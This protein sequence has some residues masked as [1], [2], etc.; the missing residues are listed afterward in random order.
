MSPLSF[1]S[2]KKRC[3]GHFSDV[4]YTKGV[5]WVENDCVRTKLT[6]CDTNVMPISSR[7]LSP[8]LFLVSVSIF[9][10]IVVERPAGLATAGYTTITSTLFLQ[11]C[12]SSRELKQKRYYD[13]Q[14]FKRRGVKKG[15]S[16]YAKILHVGLTAAVELPV[17]S[18]ESL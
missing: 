18:S 12:Q 6:S 7:Y 14:Q 9:T 13:W 15:A 11:R 2:S 3:E 16:N 1:K 5:N 4:F 8:L 10:G 17:G